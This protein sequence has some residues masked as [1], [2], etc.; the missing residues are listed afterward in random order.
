MLPKVSAGCIN[1]SVDVKNKFSVSHA[2]VSCH[3]FRLGEI[4]YCMFWYQTI[5]NSYDFSASLILW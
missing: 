3:A 1:A 2:H 5:L 4:Q